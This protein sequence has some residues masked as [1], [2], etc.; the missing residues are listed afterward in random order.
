M[1]GKRFVLIEQI[2]SYCIN[3]IGVVIF[4][5]Y[6]KIVD[7][8]VGIFNGFYFKNRKFILIKK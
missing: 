6:W 5:C 2:E 8:Y 7:Y 1:Y 4:I 3:F